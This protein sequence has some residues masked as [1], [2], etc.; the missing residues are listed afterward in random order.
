[1]SQGSLSLK[2]LR[3]ALQQVARKQAILRTAIRFDSDNGNLTQ[4]IQPNNVRE[5]FSFRTTNID[6]EKDKNMLQRIIFDEMTNRMHFD[7]IQG[8]VCRCHIVRHHSS[9]NTDDDDILT[10]DDWIIFNFHHVAFD[11]E[12]VRIFFDELHKFYN[13]EQYPENNDEK[14]TLQYIDCKLRLSRNLLC[15]EIIVT[16]NKIFSH[17]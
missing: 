2:H 6:K 17:L 16:I 10:I 12:S 7:L 13:H 1:M 5:W 11:G 3:A 14:T 4:Y 15:F 9:N 8:Q